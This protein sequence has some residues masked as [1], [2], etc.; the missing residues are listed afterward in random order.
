MGRVKPLEGEF[1][2]L[3]RLRVCSY[4][5]LFDETSDAIIIHRVSD[6][7]RGHS[8]GHRGSGRQTGDSTARP[9]AAAGVPAPLLR[10]HPEAAVE[11]FGAEG[12]ELDGIVGELGGGEA[13]FEFPFVGVAGVGFGD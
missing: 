2:G 8:R 5:L 10:Q 12:G 4:R 6:R 9:P 7:R 13:G 11:G 1:E 3:L